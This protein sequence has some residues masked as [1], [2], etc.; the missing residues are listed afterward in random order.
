M[1]SLNEELLQAEEQYSGRFR[2]AEAITD[3]EQRRT[4]LESLRN[5]FGT[6]QSMI[7]K[8]YGVRLR[9]RRTRAE[10]QAERERMGRKALQNDAD[11][12]SPA[13]TQPPSA[14]AWAAANTVSTVDL[15]GDSTPSLKRRRVDEGNND[16]RSPYP[17]TGGETTKV[18]EM[19]GGLTASSAN[20]AHYDPT[21][22][23]PNP[24]D[25]ATPSHTYQQ[26]GARV[27][28][29]LPSKPTSSVAASTSGAAD[30]TGSRDPDSMTPGA[31]ELDRQIQEETQNQDIQANAGEESEVISI[32]DDSDDYI[33][34]IPARLPDNVR[35][36][37]TSP[38]PGLSS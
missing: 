30:D 32:E 31:M 5:T 33:E 37:L 8:K 12:N 20:A 19:A 1:A 16:Y 7:R 4:R 28:I 9:E 15:T 34:D 38:Q 11:N 17:Q 2:E 27:E 23:P 24:S 26:S 29:H 10:I 13:P 21:L 22:P 14:A 25:A 36:S 6:K 35:Q 3:L 18:S